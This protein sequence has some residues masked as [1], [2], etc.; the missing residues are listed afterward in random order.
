[1]FAVARLEVVGGG[2]QLCYAKDGDTNRRK[3]IITHRGGWSQRG[4]TGV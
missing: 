1:M 3:R 4:R 2:V